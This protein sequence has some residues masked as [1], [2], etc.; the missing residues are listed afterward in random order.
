MPA[1][2]VPTDCVSVSVVFVDLLPAYSYF[3]IDIV[4]EHSQHAVADMVEG[5]AES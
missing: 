3:G 1:A 2:I 5:V 4:V